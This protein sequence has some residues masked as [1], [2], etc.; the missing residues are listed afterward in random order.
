MSTTGSVI[1][2]K[3]LAAQRVPLAASG[4][5]SH[6]LTSREVHASLVNAQRCIQTSDVCQVSFERPHLCG[7]MY[8]YMWHSLMFANRGQCAGGT[9]LG[10]AEASSQHGSWAHGRRWGIKG[11]SYSAATCCSP[12]ERA[13]HQ[14]VQGQSHSLSQAFSVS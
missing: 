10:H 2:R 13:G 3:R 8:I 6:A 11:C 4:L 1:S 14:Q 12:G 7:K 5:R 9:C